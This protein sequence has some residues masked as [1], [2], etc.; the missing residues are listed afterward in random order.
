M[1]RY[2]RPQPERWIAMK[3]VA[4]ALAAAL[5]FAAPASAED[6]SCAGPDLTGLQPVEAGR[7]RVSAGRVNLIKDGTKAAQ[8]PDASPACREKGY[9]VP[10]DLVVLGRKLNDF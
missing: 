3:R 10:G 8:C 4:M 2:G 6:R 7:I 9:L 1:K 5:A